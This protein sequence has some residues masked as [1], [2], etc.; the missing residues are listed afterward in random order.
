LGHV[1][2]WVTQR[3]GAWSEAGWG[4]DGGPGGAAAG[5]G[6]LPGCRWS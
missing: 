4:G 1:A 3:G 5:V 2:E 6:H